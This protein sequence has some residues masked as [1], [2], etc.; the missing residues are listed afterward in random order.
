MDPSRPYLLA[1]LA[2]LLA[3]PPLV[4]VARRIERKN[5][6]KWCDLER[7][8]RRRNI[9]EYRAWQW[10]YGKPRPRCLTDQRPLKGPRRKI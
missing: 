2:L 1:L 8:R 7:G 5:H 9:A 6:E 10:L 3:I 4:A